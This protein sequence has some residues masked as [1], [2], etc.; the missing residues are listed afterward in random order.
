MRVRRIVSNTA[1][2]AVWLISAVAALASAT[3]WGRFIWSFDWG[4]SYRGR[5]LWIF[6]AFLLPT[7]LIF[8]VV[9][10]VVLMVGTRIC[11]AIFPE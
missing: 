3:G 10:Y 1:N 8:I 6:Y 11:E 2:A 4:T 5:G 9:F 7:A